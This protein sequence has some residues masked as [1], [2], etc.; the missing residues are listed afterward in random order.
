MCG[1]RR[2]SNFPEFLEFVQQFDLLCFTETKINQTDVIS[3]PG[4]DCIA[5]P[6]KQPFRRRSGG[7]SIYFKDKF[8][9][10][11]SKIDTASDYVS[12]ISIDK[13]LTQLDEN[14]ILGSVYIPPE[15]SL[16]YN[17]EEM[18]TLENE[19]SSFCGENKYVLLTGDFNARTA[20]L[21][22][23]TEPDTFLPEYFDFDDETSE[24]FYSVSKLDSYNIP[25]D[26]KSMDKHTNNI[27]YKLIDICKNNN[28][29][30]CNGRIGNDKHHGKLTF[31]KVSV[32]DYTISSVEALPYLQ[33][34]EVQ[35]T[36][37]LFSDGHNLLSCSVVLPRNETITPQRNETTYPPKWDEKYTNA[38]FGNI[39]RNEI[40]SIINFLNS[41]VNSKND[42]NSVTERISDIFKTANPSLSL[43]PVK[44]EIQKGLGLERIV[45]RPDGSTI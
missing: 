43:S 4:Y 35:E 1:L 29:F 42:I 14:L 23:Y 26:R 19:I 21:C 22:D 11:I 45:K 34:F 37:S 41:S 27:G 13:S 3:F 18:T 7:I 32:I 39:D 17:N 12:W 15:C 24:F 16:F 20:V 9:R 33:K 44:K 5:Q 6:R 10:F 40:S 36:D 31:K 38:F 30:L 8:S 25:K 2:R 28:M